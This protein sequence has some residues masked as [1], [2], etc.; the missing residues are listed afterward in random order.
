MFVL[1]PVGVQ[2][3]STKRERQGESG[4]LTPMSVVEDTVRRLVKQSSGGIILTGAMP[5]FRNLGAGI[6]LGR[7]EFNPRPLHV[8]FVVDKVAL[9]PDFL[10]VFRFL[11]PAEFYR[12]SILIHSAITD[13]I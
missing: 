1:W 13:A 9:G 6:S 11:L 3:S 5:R 4:I 8:E 10:R 12:C 7:P 2:R